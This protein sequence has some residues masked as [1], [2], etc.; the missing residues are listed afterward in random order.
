MKVNQLITLLEVSDEE[1]KKLFQ[2]AR[3]GDLTLLDRPDLTTVKDEIGLTL[4]HILAGVA[5]DKRILNHPLAASIKNRMGYTPLHYM[6]DNGNKNVLSHPD[7]D[8]VKNNRGDTP[9]DILSTYTGQSKQEL[10][11]EEDLYQTKFKNLNKR[12]DLD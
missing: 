3:E 5:D 6:A 9:L 11:D 1:R 12:I 4:L 8:K 10:K 7:V 2:R